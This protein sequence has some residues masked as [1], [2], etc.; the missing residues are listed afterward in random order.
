VNSR[1]SLS[2]PLAALVLLV[3]SAPAA[4]SGHGPLFGAATPVLG[5]GSWSLD[6]ALMGRST[7]E[8]IAQTLRTMIGFGITEDIQVSASLPFDLGTHPPLPGGRMMAMM[9]SNREF[10][11]LGAWR[12]H[13][14]PVGIGGRFETTL[15]GGWT[16][17]LDDSAHGHHISQSFSVSA[18][19]GF[20]S[21]AHYFWLGAG[22]QQYVDDDGFRPSS[23]SSYSVVYGYRPPAWR[24]EYP[25]P[26][27]R[28]FAEVVGERVGRAR[29]HGAGDN[30]SGGT[31]VFAGPSILAL[32]K[33]YGLE[34]GVQFPLYRDMR[35]GVPDERF[36]FGVN[37]AYFFWI[38]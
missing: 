7:D 26:D 24:L 16:T 9:S 17:P 10:E 23:V 31:A 22:H 25:R 33:A 12:V 37:F 6:A 13:T 19:S 2:L 5:K 20:A 8:A 3:S 18:A 36:R 28:L 27:V 35:P 21:R 32:Y 34:A 1:R 4:A 30:G 15:F 14:R 11:V 29:F 38:K